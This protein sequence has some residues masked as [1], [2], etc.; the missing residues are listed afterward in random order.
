MPTTLPSAVF[1]RRPG[2]AFTLIELLVVVAIIA[3]LLAVLLPSL[4]RARE[5]GRRGVCLS[6]L[7]QLGNGFSHYATDNGSYF[8]GVG[9]SYKYY[10]KEGG[11]RVNL[12]GLYDDHGKFA[13]KD[14]SLYFCPSN[15]LA[16][17]GDF[18]IEGNPNNYGGSGFLD[19][20][21]PHTFSAYMYAVPMNW[22]QKGD[23]DGGRHPRDA[24]KD[25]YP[26][27]GDVGLD[28]R[29]M[30]VPKYETWL[31][32]KRGLKG[33]TE[34]GERAVHALAADNYIAS[35]NHG[36][37][38]IGALTHKAGYNVLFTDFH[39][40]WVGEAPMFRDA[41]EQG[42]PDPSI[43]RPKGPT[44]NA[45]KNFETWNYFSRNP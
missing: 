30:L 11:E 16:S 1:T 26:D 29:S 7:H 25:A 9:F 14:L 2:T 15:P 32:Q 34:Y 41:L 17:L 24:G 6:N 33:S 45:E 36:G 22:S 19:P 31:T 42:D 44:K 5:Q 4:A 12:G 3:L 10:M 13:G 43:A 40:K 27:V 8:P 37:L 38:G 18:Y 23:P 20:D 28:G 21:E 35:A 39:A